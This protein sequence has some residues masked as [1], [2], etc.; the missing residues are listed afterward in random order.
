[1]I[2]TVVFD[3][4]NV[5]IDWNAHLVWKDDFDTPAEI[6]SFLEVIGFAAWNAEQDRGRTFAE[7][8]A[9]LSARFP[10]HAS[11]IAKY[12]HDWIKSI[13]TAHDESVAVLDALQSAGT[14]VYA[15]TNFS[16]EKWPVAVARFPFLGTFRDTVVSGSE[17]LVKPDPAIYRV[18]IERNGLDPATCVF[19][20]DKPVNCDG[21]RAV[22]MDA[23]HFTGGAALATALRER[24][25]PA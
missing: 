13:P 12:D 16:A 25:L 2:T 17:R 5:L 14:P 21:A 3:V 10:A 4:G 18:L 19:I 8:T 24:G 9:E 23:I 7:G 11:L 6:D 1:M 22:G 20:D 15:V